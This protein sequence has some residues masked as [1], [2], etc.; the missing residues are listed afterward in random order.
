MSRY[1]ITAALPYTN[2][3]PHVGHIAGAYLPADIYVRFL[4]Q[5]GN[6]VV[7][8]C[9]SD[10]HGVPIIMSARREGVEPSDI[11]AKYRGAQDS[12][13]RGLGI[14]FDIYSGTS[15]CPVH[16]EL[17]QEFFTRLHDRG[18]LV[19][20]DTD[21]FYC[22]NCEQFL[23][24]RFVEGTCPHCGTAGA[25]GDQCDTCTRSYEQT[26]L[27]EP[28]CVT[29]NTT[30]EIRTTRHWFF[31]LD[32]YRDRL[33][34]WLEGREDWRDT[35]RNYCLGLLREE[36]PERSITRDL[37]WGVPVPL[38]EAEGK[39]MYVWFD[40]PIGYLSFTKELFESRGEPEGWR[41]YWESEDTQLVHFIGKDNI[42]FHAIIW[43][44]MLMGHGDFVIPANV[45]ANEYLN[46]GG[47]KLAKSTGNVVWVEDLLKDYP[48]DL[49]R[50]YL[51]AVAPEGRDTSF[52]IE[53]FIT[54]SN[55]VLS[56]VVGN[57]CHRV[58]TFANKTFDG[59]VPEGD[60]SDPTTRALL[61]KIG[62]AR[63]QWKS[64]AD[65]V[66]LRETLGI[67]VDLA[68]EG[69]RAFDAAEPWKT[70]KSDLERCAFDIRA[71]LELVH[72][73]AVLFGPFLPTASAKLRE[74]FGL[75][76]ELGPD[77]VETL[78]SL[79]LTT[80]AELGAPGVLFPRLELPES[81]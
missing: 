76:A 71:G 80:G 6:D 68:R 41:E 28:Y 37:T 63:D 1:L 44:A 33:R 2:N 19:P 49:L 27:K 17:A 40:A 62:E 74:A 53:D 50:Y 77:S 55:E 4:R 64:A 57:L 16:A 34:E 39:V 13:F 36:L 32:A 67:V 42:V 58:F 65:G 43:P 14:E 66:R 10:D 15:T 48:A 51:A 54:K 59:R 7:F 46:F 20:R 78:G 73:L 5:T 26:E 21:Q 11:V 9:G 12:A 47:K 24:D 69:N 38:E 70:K 29:C 22:P 45:P 52:T 3:R 25:R 79:V 31:K 75:P 23:P 81:E 30:P 60:P 18:E 72:A 61:D 56:G 35:V 8:I